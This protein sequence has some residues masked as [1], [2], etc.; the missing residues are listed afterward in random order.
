MDTRQ[1]KIILWYSLTDQDCATSDLR[2]L[3]YGLETTA[4]LQFDIHDK[5]DLK[6][7]HKLASAKLAFSKWVDLKSGF[8]FQATDSGLEESQQPT[9]ISSSEKTNMSSVDDRL[10]RE[11]SET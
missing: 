7:Q 3:L 10:K 11:L 6:V 9:E 2:I 5:C 4:V 8:H 1:S